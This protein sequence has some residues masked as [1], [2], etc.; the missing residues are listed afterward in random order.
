M[1]FA[2]ERNS[3][4]NADGSEG[5]APAPKPIR[6]RVV[7]FWPASIF[8]EG[9]M[10]ERWFVGTDYIYKRQNKKTLK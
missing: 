3:A 6:N 4:S 8:G 7:Y 10:I 5:K 1:T 2:T 9:G